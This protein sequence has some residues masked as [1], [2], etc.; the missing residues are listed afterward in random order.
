MKTLVFLKKEYKAEKIIKKIED[1]S[2]VG[3]IDDIE[4]FSFKG[5]QDFSLF[6]LK[7]ND[8]YDVEITAQKT[9]LKEIADLKLENMKKDKIL[10]NT[11][12]TVADLK[13]EILNMKGGK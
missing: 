2:I 4:V 7:E 8:Q 6:A 3:Y 12:K 9:V 5:I 1:K 11:L 13:L 10:S